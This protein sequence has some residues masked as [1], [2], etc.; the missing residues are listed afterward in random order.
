MAELVA[1]RSFD[2]PVEQLWKAWAH[3]E[4]LTRG[5]QRLDGSGRQ[6]G[7]PRGRHFTRLLALANRS[8]AVQHVDVPASHSE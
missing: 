4:Y 5:P 1:T 2:A 8:R 6:V 3:L 7:C